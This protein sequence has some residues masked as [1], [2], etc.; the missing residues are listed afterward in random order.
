[1]SFLEQKTL[2]MLIADREFGLCQVDLIDL[3]NGSRAPGRVNKAAQES[4]QNAADTMQVS[5]Q[6][7]T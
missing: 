7:L 1:M 6:L 3:E 4:A 5:A 2:P